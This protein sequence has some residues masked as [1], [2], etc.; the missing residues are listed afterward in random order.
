MVNAGDVEVIAGEFA[1]SVSCSAV[2]VDMVT[3]AGAM[4]AFDF[5]A[6]LEQLKQFGCWAAFDCWPLALLD[7]AHVL[8]AWMPSYHV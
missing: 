3:V 4:A 8:Q 2:T 6:I 1:D 7:C 5:A